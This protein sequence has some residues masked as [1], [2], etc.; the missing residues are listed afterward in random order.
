MKVRFEIAFT[1][2]LAAGCQTPPQPVNYAGG[3]G[4]CCQKAVVINNAKF[5][6]TGEL[7]ERLWLDQRYP[8]RQETKQSS[9]DSAGRHFDV[10]N[11]ATADGRK[12]T[13]Y[14]DAT[15]WFAK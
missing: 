2:L 15:D 4:S 10:I 5:R 8:G 11:L 1:V 3:D 14:F 13:V 12:A 9:L 6:E 7:A